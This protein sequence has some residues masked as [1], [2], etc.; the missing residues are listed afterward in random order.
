MKTNSLFSATFYHKSPS[1]YLNSLTESAT[2]TSRNFT[3]ASR[4]CKIVCKRGLFST[5]A[6]QA[7]K[8]IGSFD[9]FFL[10]RQDIDSDRWKLSNWGGSRC[11][12]KFASDAKLPRNSGNKKIAW[13]LNDVT[14]RRVLPRNGIFVGYKSMRLVLTSSLSHC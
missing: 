2:T 6:K 14:R 12:F 10:S 8:V 4:V 11:L 1:W 9:D 3:P 13:R 7:L 5:T